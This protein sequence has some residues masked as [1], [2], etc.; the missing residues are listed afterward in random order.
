MAARFRDREKSLEG[1]L[2]VMK[3]DWEVSLKSRREI[4]DEEK[5]ASV[6]SMMTGIPVQKL[7]SEEEKTENL[8]PVLKSKVIAQ[9]KAIDTL[10]KAIRRSRCGLKNPNK[11]IGSFLFLGPTGVGKTLLAK[12]LA[13]QMFGTEDALIGLT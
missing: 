11:P 7:A 3:R 4:V 1:E 10:A 6:V 13:E 12:Q 8:S 5:I 9:D 2:E